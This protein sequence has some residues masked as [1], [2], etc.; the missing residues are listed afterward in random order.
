MDNYKEKYL[1]YILGTPEMGTEGWTQYFY[2][3][4]TQGNTIEEVMAD[5]KKNVKL[6]YDVDVN[7]KLHT[8]GKW[9]SYYEITYNK[10]PHDVKGTCNQ[11]NINR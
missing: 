8:N 9:Y 5:Y 10:L 2:Y 1:V 6:L 4:L 7:P 11:L 3:A